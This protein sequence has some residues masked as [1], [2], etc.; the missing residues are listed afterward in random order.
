MLNVICIFSRLTS[1]SVRAFFAQVE[2]LGKITDVPL[3]Y[4]DLLSYRH[5]QCAVLSATGQMPWLGSC[6]HR[7]PDD[8]DSTWRLEVALSLERDAQ[9]QQQA[10]PSSSVPV[11]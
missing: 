1:E 9:Q 3:L 6:E 10:K 7:T 4:S 11:N 8:A 5:F 2:Y